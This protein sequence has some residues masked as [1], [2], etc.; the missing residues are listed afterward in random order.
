MQHHTMTG[1][2]R[3]GLCCFC[4]DLQLEGSFCFL[5]S[6]PNQNNP[7]PRKKSVFFSDYL[8]TKRTCP[9]LWVFFA[10][11]RQHFGPREK[12]NSS[13]SFRSGNPFKKKTTKFGSETT[14]GFIGGGPFE[15]MF[16]LF[17]IDSQVVFFLRFS[18]W[19]K[20]R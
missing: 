9:R 7:V 6:R 3:V 16:P 12:N 10:I 5:P 19:G 17:G 14:P 4:R 1:L 8:F 18:A 11:T 2:F 13:P 20:C 15:G